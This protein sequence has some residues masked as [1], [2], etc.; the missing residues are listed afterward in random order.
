MTRVERVAKQAPGVPEFRIL[1][2]FVEKRHDFGRNRLK[3]RRRQ[4][5]H[6]LP[7][8]RIL[9]IP[10]K[11]RLVGR[12]QKPSHHTGKR[13]EAGCCSA[14]FFSISRDQKAET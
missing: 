4:L 2:M 3:C 6:P 14:L 7:V 8:G 12:R 10:R 5:F 1:R 9:R 13:H 11:P